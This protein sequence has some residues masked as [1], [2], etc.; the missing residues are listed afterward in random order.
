MKKYH[1]NELKILFLILPFIAVGCQP[2]GENQMNADTSDKVVQEISD[3]LEAYEKA[4]VSW[5]REAI[6]RFWGDSDS[7]VFAGDGIILGGHSEWAETLDRYEKTVEKWLKFEYT[8]THIEALSM[9]AAT[10]TTEFEHSRISVEGDKVNI[11]GSWTYV[12]KKQDG[13]WNVIHA[14]GTH[15][16]F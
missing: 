8:S 7:F 6:N 15:V 10:A 12:F 2:K 1:W 11:R 3:I 13:K 5:D 14:N 16:E 9:D 4:V